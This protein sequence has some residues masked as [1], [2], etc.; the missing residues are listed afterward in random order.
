MPVWLL[1]LHAGLN[2]MQG[3]FAMLERELEAAKANGQDTTPHSVALQAA[4]DAAASLQ[5]AADHPSVASVTS[6]AAQ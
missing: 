6:S 5:A 3:L 2:M 4:K 1:G